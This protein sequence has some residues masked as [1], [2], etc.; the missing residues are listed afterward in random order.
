VHCLLT[1]NRYRHFAETKQI[2]G[3]FFFFLSFFLSVSVLFCFLPPSR[4]FSL[5]FNKAE[6]LVRS[7]LGLSGRINTL[8]FL[9]LSLSLSSFSSRRCFI[10]GEYPSFY[11]PF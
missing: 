4:F 11:L 1:I 5:S 7:A 9:S 3:Q 2:K 10:S 6:A 8:V